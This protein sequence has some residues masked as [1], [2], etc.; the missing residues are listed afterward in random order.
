[1]LVLVLWNCRGEAE[2]RGQPS[3]G[4]LTV[5]DPAIQDRVEAEIEALDVLRSSLGRSVAGQEVDEDL[6]NVVCKPVGARAAEL[7]E[8]NGWMVR[9]LAERNR[10]PGNVLDEEARQAFD[11]MLADAD[12]TDFWVRTTVEGAAASRYFRRIN[13][14]AA[15]LSCHG[16]AETRP[17]FVVSG[18][19]DDRA[20]GFREGDLRGVY[21]VIVRDSALPD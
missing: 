2:Q 13:V 11:V 12:L 1:V 9:Q 17:D 21:S 7:S 6:F 8:A 15:C 4:G 10:N 5:L 16:A 14:E 3:P 19:P 20:Y 18:Y